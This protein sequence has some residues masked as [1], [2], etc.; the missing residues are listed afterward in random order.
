MAFDNHGAVCYLLKEKVGGNEYN[1][2][3]RGE[4]VHTELMELEGHIL[5]AHIL[6][7]VLDAII[8]YGGD[9]RIVDFQ[10]GRSRQ[11]PSRARIEIWAQETEHLEQ[12]TSRVQDL[13]AVM[14]EEE[15]AALRQAPDN[16]VFPEGFYVTTNL[17]TRVRVQGSWFTVEDTEMDCGLVVDADA[18]KARCLPVNRVRAGEQVVVG[19]R[20]I[21]VT[22]LERDRSRDVFSFMG[23]AVS[24][25][26]PKELLIREVAAAMSRLREDPEQKVVVVAG[27][28]LIHTGAGQYLDRI[29]AGGYVDCLLAGNALAAH[30]VE[31]ALLGTS[32]GIN[33]EDGAP[34]PQGHT[35]HL[36]AI[37]SIRAC[38]GLARAVEAGVLTSGVMHTCVTHQVDYVLAGSIRDDGP[39]PDTITD[40]IEA[41][42]EMRHRLQGTSLVLM[43]GSMLHSIAVGNMLPASVRTVC[44]D[45]NP[46][47]VTKLADR[48]SL[49]TVGLVSDVEWFLRELALRLSLV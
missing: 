20:G 38:G 1:F 28:A 22:P 21:Q 19:H 15:E 36:R 33:L 13:G 35:H 29:L 6:P 5:D 44:V 39:L 23:S 48:G 14:L 7:R 43:L 40:V 42:E 17:E 25:E 49:Q 18:G 9:F 41:Q 2:I 46:A 26:R 47:V 8:D 16:G 27:P 11:D 37:N 4:G 34:A 31:H 32:L 30:D 3:M 10:V 12:I 24:S 45:I